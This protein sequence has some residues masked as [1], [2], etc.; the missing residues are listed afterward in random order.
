MN[1]LVGR[2]RPLKRGFDIDDP[3]PLDEM[4]HVRLRHSCHSDRC[5]ITDIRPQ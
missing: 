5:K 2:M 3:V 1:A 4:P